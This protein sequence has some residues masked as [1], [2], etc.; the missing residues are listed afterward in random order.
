MS[1][2]S[3]S[4][5]RLNA[6]EFALKADINRS[7]V[8]LRFGFIVPLDRCGGILVF[9]ASSEHLVFRR[10]RSQP[11]SPSWMATGP[12]IPHWP[13]AV[14]QVIILLLRPPDLGFL[15]QNATRGFRRSAR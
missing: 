7:K 2:R 9:P 6:S 14:S 12:R 1:R 13:T 3:A 5:F 15:L 4:L 11:I 8:N 10:A